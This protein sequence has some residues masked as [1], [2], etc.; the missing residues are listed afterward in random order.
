[1]A[2]GALSV[3]ESSASAVL[4]SRPLFT[5]GTLG[6]ASLATT[7]SSAA[8]DSA[9]QTLNVDEDQDSAIGGMSVVTTTMSLN[10]SVYDFLEENG[11]TYHR[12]KQGS[13]ATTSVYTEM[14]RLDLQHQLWLLTLNDELHLAPI[15]NPQHVLD[16]GTGTG[17]W[18]IEFATK[19]SSS[20]VIGNDLSPIQPTY[21]PSNCTFEL[22]DVEDPWSYS[23]P[24]DYIHGRALATSFQDIRSVITSAFTSLSPGGYLELQDGALP[25]RSI[26]S[27]LSGTSLDLWQ[28]LTISAA[29]KLGKSW[30]AVH[31]YVQFME[32]AG[33]VD[34]VETHFQWPTSTWAKGE[35]VKLLGRYWQEDLNRGLE[36]ISMAALTRAGGMSKEEVLELTGRARRDVFDK[37]IH[38]YMPVVVVYGRKP[39]LN[40]VSI[41]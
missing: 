14:D 6:Q 30:D 7:S 2:S 27:S 25:M 38:A 26:D 1:M 22:D 15:K 29:A 41:R 21:I 24:F 3:E 33:F 40:E 17:I 16:I 20:Q 13:W 36:A 34:V 18:A 10:A 32:E 31:T 28:H 4:N 37:N 9:L 39:A 11:R 8:E 12:Y 35:R 5:N 19:H 23:H